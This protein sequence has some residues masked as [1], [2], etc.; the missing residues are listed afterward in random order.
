MFVFSLNCK[1]DATSDEARVSN[2]S[3]P[4]R[5]RANDFS[6]PSFGNTVRPGA[7]GTIVVGQCELRAE[8][9]EASQMLQLV[10]LSLIDPRP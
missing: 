2:R 10:N 9:L 3:V 1:Y 8:G 4:K 5:G 7:L 6:C